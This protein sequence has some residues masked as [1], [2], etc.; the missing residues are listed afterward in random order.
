MDAL[1]DFIG[2]RLG[3][4]RISVRELAKRINAPYAVVN[5]VCR[6][7]TSIDPMM[8]GDWCSALQVDGN[9]RDTLINLALMS[10]AL[11]R[12]DLAALFVSYQEALKDRE[13]RE[14]LWAERYEALRS[15]AL[16][17]IGSTTIEEARLLLKEGLTVSK[18]PDGLDGAADEVH[19]TPPPAAPLRDPSEAKPLDS[20]A[21]DDISGATRFIGDFHREHDALHW[22]YDVRVTDSTGRLVGGDI[23]YTAG[24]A[25][26]ESRIKKMAN[27]LIKAGMP[28]GCYLLTIH[29]KTPAGTSWTMARLIASETTSTIECL[30]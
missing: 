18:D 11:H 6:G 19:V 26:V 8:L 9:D 15:A 21:S 7:K 29:R 3:E 30:E 1:K 12:T 28:Q 20:A 27:R 4:L 14:E 13:R 10:R 17:A 25:K 2:R 16:R 24:M 23:F 22:I 5:R